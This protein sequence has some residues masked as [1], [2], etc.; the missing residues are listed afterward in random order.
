[1]EKVTLS[2]LSKLISAPI[3]STAIFAF[4]FWKIFKFYREDIS[5]IVKQNT[6]AL[7][8]LS[9]E[10]EEHTDAVLH[11]ER[12]NKEREIEL[13]KAMQKVARERGFKADA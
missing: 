3:G 7:I 6:E 12:R 9:E 4:L 8:R 11:R 10:V 1:M 5:T 13:E 2:V